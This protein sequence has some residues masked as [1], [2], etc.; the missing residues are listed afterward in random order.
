[1]ESLSVPGRRPMETGRLPGAFLRS[2]TRNSNSRWRSATYSR[3]RRIFSSRSA[4][5]RPLT[6]RNAAVRANAAIPVSSRYGQPSAARCLFGLKALG[7][8]VRKAVRPPY[9]PAPGRGPGRPPLIVAESDAA[10]VPPLP[11]LDPVPQLFLAIDYSGLAQAIAHAEQVIRSTRNTLK[12]L[13]HTE[14]GR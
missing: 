2:A 4:S 7:E 14:Q 6:W 9:R 13:R 5:S 1:L 12:R 11:A 10:P 3:S 8:E